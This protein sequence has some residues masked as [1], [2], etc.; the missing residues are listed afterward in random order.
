[1]KKKLW[2]VTPSKFEINAIQPVLS[3]WSCINDWEIASSIIGVGIMLSAVQVFDLLNKHP[4]NLIILAGVAGSYVPKQFNKTVVV[5]EEVLGGRGSV[6]PYNAAEWLD[7]FDKGLDDPNRPCF[8]NGVLKNPN[9]ALMKKTKLPLAKGLTSD[10][11]TLD[12]QRVKM[13]KK[14]Y[15]PDIESMEGASFFYACLLKQIPFLHIRTICNEVGIPV[16]V[17]KVR[18]ALAQLSA[19]LSQTL[20]NL[21][22]IA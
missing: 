5:T 22:A 13:L 10:E 1:M 18:E 20:K 12:R 7:I 9:L 21:E 3:S 19:D 17:A 14:K 4:C 2:L 15:C 16:E 11:V 8:T 6:N